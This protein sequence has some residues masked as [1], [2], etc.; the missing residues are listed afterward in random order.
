MVPVTSEFI[1]ATLGSSWSSIYDIDGAAYRTADELF[2]TECATPQEFMRDNM[3][4]LRALQIN[5]AVRC[6]PMC[7]DSMNDEFGAEHWRFLYSVSHRLRFLIVLKFGY[8]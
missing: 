7:D 1:N 2:K 3:E 8:Y 6:G 5:Y 4:N